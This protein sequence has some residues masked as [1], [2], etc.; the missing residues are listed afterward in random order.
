MG[1]QILLFKI[2]LCPE[3]RSLY[4]NHFITRPL[5]LPEIANVFEPPPA[6]DISDPKFRNECGFETSKCDGFAD[7]NTA[8]TIFEFES[9]RTL[10]MVLED[11]AL[12]SGLRCNSEKTVLMQVGRKLDVSY[13]I[14][15]LGF[16]LADSIHILGMDIDSELELLDNNFDRT[17]DSLKKSIDFWKR[18]HL[19]L[20]GRINV[21]KSLLISQV[22][23]LGSF[24]MPSTVKFKKI[25]DLLDKFA[26]GKM[27]F[28]V[29]RISLP[30]DQRGLGLFD[31]ENFLMAQQAGWILKAKKSSRDNWRAK[32]RNL[33]YNNILCA[34]PSLISKQVNPILHTLSSSFERI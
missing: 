29:N 33:C 1:Q 32:L 34:G 18:F 4:Q 23:Y 14:K 27:N 19:T 21:I 17:L 15:S 31:L 9:L 11:F 30:C 16:T 26:L 7:D 22:I 24:L 3:I 2:E 20:P 28:A 12:F 25:Q 5:K 10:K 6:N 13:E 8:G